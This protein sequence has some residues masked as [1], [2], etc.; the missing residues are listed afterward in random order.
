MLPGGG[1]DRRI[2]DGVSDRRDNILYII[3]NNISIKKK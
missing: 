1:E 3:E 2:L